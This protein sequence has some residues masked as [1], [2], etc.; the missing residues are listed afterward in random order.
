MSTGAT[1]SGSHVAPGSSFMGK[2]EV[3]G[4]A[5]KA[6][7]N[8]IDWEVLWLPTDQA[9]SEDPPV[10]TLKMSSHWLQGGGASL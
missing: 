6:L 10:M 3:V 1:L 8:G 2:S 9:V 5:S 7:M 4:G